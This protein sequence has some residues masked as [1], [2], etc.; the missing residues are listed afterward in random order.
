[1]CGVQGMCTFTPGHNSRFPQHHS[2]LNISDKESC[3][4]FS[5]TECSTCIVLEYDQVVYF[6]ILHCTVVPF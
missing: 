6:H 3:F 4:F 2:G 5:T 1:M